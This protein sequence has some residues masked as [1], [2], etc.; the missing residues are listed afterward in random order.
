MA[1]QNELFP[2]PFC[3]AT[4]Q[5][6]ERD[7]RSDDRGDIGCNTP[8][9]IAEGG[10]DWY[11]SKDDIQ[12]KWNQRP[13]ATHHC[14]NCEAAARELAELQALC[15]REAA[16]LTAVAVA[17]RGPEPPQTVYG[18]ADLPERAKSAMREIADLKSDKAWADKLSAEN[19]DELSNLRREHEGMTGVPVICGCGDHIG[20]AEV[21]GLSQDGAVCGNCAVGRKDYDARMELVELRERVNMAGE[22]ADSYKHFYEVEIELAQQY[23]RDRESLHSGIERI[24]ADYPRAIKQDAEE[25]FR[26]LLAE[27][28][29]AK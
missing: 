7:A 21:I 26:A 8:G 5:W 17:L 20:Y 14:P 10:F 3:N 29:A 27:T 12:Q 6:I 15:D 22:L 11:L 4:P 9:C 25:A 2:C 1:V 23:Y 16:L 24:L 18:W 19:A 13:Q 28:E